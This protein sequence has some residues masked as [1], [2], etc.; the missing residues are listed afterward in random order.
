MLSFA[1]IEQKGKYVSEAL[2]RKY[3]SKRLDEVVGQEHV[4]DILR[5]ALKKGK[6]SHAYLLTGPRG[7]GKT[8]IARILAHEI[9][10]L[11]YDGTAHL[12]IIEIDAASNNSVEDI[13]D[14]REKV[15]IAP[16]T[17]QKK[18][19]II[20]EVHML[21]K[22]AFNA[23]LKTLEEP[24][25]HVVFILATTEV[26]KVPD[27]I[28]SRTQ[29][30]HFRPIPPDIMCEHLKNIAKK[31]KISIDDDAL[32]LIAERARG[33]F[34]DSISL[35]DQIK[36][37]SDTTITRASLEQHLGIAPHDLITKL[38]DAMTHQQLKSA[39]S[40]C[41]HI[42]QAG[43]S[44][45]V[46]AEQ[47]ST[48]IVN[49]LHDH[50]ELISVLHELIEVNKSSDPYLK[51]LSIIAR[52]S[53]GTSKNTPKTLALAAHP[54]TSFSVTPVPQEASKLRKKHDTSKTPRQE[55]T[56]VF[57]KTTSTESDSI[58]W[59]DVLEKVRSTSMPLYSMLKRAETTQ[60]KLGLT[61]HVPFSLHQKK[62]ESAAHQKTL[63]G[64]LSELYRHSPSLHITSG[65]R[66]PK[67]E[68]AR[69]IADIMGGGEEITI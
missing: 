42:D 49:Q 47:L 34:R 31:E 17:A 22:P 62:L 40:L 43:I 29:R 20:D 53:A 33:S 51:F 44:P 13:R 61:I 52:A 57:H 9:N 18:I 10:H 25:S 63:H 54:P 16:T 24:P 12:D 28:L 21:S 11:P 38:F 14:L 37:I 41:Q 58:Q 32:L 65:K 60:T 4:T 55:D 6:T 8:S 23:L 68:Q 48:Y 5:N 36:H 26:Y 50:P 39:V 27:T 7:V 45:S 59:A 56:S 2:Y 35:L 46:A 67:N 66:L 1:I 69:A 30:F 15:S 64:I 19:Y 3:R